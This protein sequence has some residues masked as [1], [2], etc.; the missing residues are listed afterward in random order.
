[1]KIVE[2]TCAKLNL[3]VSF[4]DSILIHCGVI[5]LESSLLHLATLEV[6]SHFNNLSV[7]YR[8]LCYM[9]ITSQ[10]DDCIVHNVIACDINLHEGDP[11][12]YMLF[13]LYSSNMCL[14]TQHSSLAYIKLSVL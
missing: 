6:E 9:R 14:V 3:V 4:I 10:H 1:M 11:R 7:I 12:S 13:A 8:H 2:V 5:Q